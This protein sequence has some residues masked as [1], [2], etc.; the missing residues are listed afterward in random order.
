[1]NE[2]L[3]RVERQSPRFQLIRRE[4][5][6]LRLDGVYHF[7]AAAG[8]SAQVEYK[9]TRHELE[10]VFAQAMSTFSYKVNGLYH[11]RNWSRADQFRCS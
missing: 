10:A 6:R 9:A 3:V 1:M 7:V 5:E 11:N 2:Y 8:T 4:I